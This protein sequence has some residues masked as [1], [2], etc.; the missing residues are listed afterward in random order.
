MLKIDGA[1]SRRKVEEAAVLKASELGISRVKLSLTEA[2]RRVSR[3]IPAPNK[4]KELH[5]LNYAIRILASDPTAGIQEITTAMDNI[6][7]SLREEGTDELALYGIRDFPAFY[8]NGKR[9]ILDIRNA[10]AAEY[11]PVSA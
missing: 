5:N 10:F 6:I 8:A 7:K 4:G 9:S 3:L 1:A 11:A 2:E